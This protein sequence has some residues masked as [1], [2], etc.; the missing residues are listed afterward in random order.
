MRYLTFVELD[1]LNSL[2]K[3]TAMS[4]VLLK[5]SVHGVSSQHKYFKALWQCQSAFYYNLVAVNCGGL[6]S[7]LIQLNTGKEGIF[8]R[9][10]FAT[11]G[12]LEGI[13]KP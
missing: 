3:T 4:C 12:V 9:A 6:E 1:G 13:T 10:I 2:N 11:Y 8:N 7:G 5:P